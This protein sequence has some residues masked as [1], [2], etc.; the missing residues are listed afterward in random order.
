LFCIFDRLRCE[1][2]WWATAV[3][4]TARNDVGSGLAHPTGFD[5]G[6]VE[7]LC[8]RLGR[9]NELAFQ[10]DRAARTIRVALN[11]AGF[12]SAIHVLP[13]AERL[14]WPADDR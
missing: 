9:T 2:R 5:P 12:R 4:C 7:D 6:F 10:A 11:G 8:G 13:D 14:G 1:R 3:R